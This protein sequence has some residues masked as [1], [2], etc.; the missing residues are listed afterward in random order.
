MTFRIRYIA[1]GLGACYAVAASIALFVE[2]RM[3]FRGFEDFW[4]PALVVPALTSSA[5]LIGDSCHLA[6][7]T[8]LLI[9]AAS[10]G[11]SD[12]K[13]SGLVPVFAVAAG[14]AFVLVAMIDRAAALLPSRVTDAAMLD[15]LAV[16]FIATRSGV[17]IAAIFLLGCF[18]IAFAVHRRRTL[19]RWFVALSLVIGAIAAAFVLVPAPIPVALAV[20][21]FALASVS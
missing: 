18:V 9:L 12:R 7:G 17:L 20:W 21:A 10:P 13:L 15:V 4:N 19:P 5:W 14:T 11:A 16:G 8:L 2:P 3:G 6:S 1:A